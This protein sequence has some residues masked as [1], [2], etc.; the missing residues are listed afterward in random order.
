MNVKVYLV[1]RRKSAVCVS[2]AV[3]CLIGL[4]Y[5]SSFQ[6]KSPSIHQTNAAASVGVAEI[7]K[8]FSYANSKADAP[9]PKAVIVSA[10]NLTIPP[11][12]LSM[13]MLAA[14]QA[15]A[16]PG[17][18]IAPAWNPATPSTGAVRQG[19]LYLRQSLPTFSSTKSASSSATPQQLLAV[20]AA[21]Y[22]DTP[23][24]S[25]FA[26]VF[27]HGSEE[28]LSAPDPAKP[29]D[30]TPTNPFSEAK[31]K[32]EAEAPPPTPVAAAP[33]PAPPKETPPPADQSAKPTPS[34]PVTVPKPA[35]P[36]GPY[37][38]LGDFNG[39]GV[40]AAMS[41][42]RIDD[43]TFAFANGQR[44]FNLYINPA[45]VELQRSFAVDDFNGDGMADILVTSRAALF[46]A[47]RLGD[48]KGN[49][50]L[51]DTFVTGYEPT[52]PVPGLLQGTQRDILSVNMRTGTV[53]T[54]RKQDRYSQVLSQNL[55]NFLPDFVAR[56]T[57]MA[58][59][60]DRFIAAQAGKAVQV[61]QWQD[62]GTL[63]SSSDSIPPDPSIVLYKDF[64]QEGATGI[65]Q[66]YQVG[67]SAS[68]LLTIHSQ[69]FNVANFRVFPQIFL[70][71]G[72]LTKRGN[73]DVA[74]AYLLSSNTSK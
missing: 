13:E 21:Q 44:V 73:L 64:L 9:V 40:L 65:L 59:D 58:S 62:D 67:S 39:T 6:S 69:S 45:A 16:R 8:P 31:Q 14:E 17:G 18:D 74:V 27:K 24:Q 23:F 60:S 5:S 3:L 38:V 50:Q 66:V 51:A 47:L 30:Q 4:V 63:A 71:F 36:D 48:D 34:T 54:F 22:L 1:L 72:D 2:L 46:G 19:M 61:Y 43:G 49:F 25:L 41:A 53:V 68:V 52:V 7:A 32:A 35:A 20:G 33:P 28:S 55:I 11:D 57:E 70:V 15:Q 42:S 56:A 26:S 12:D 37:T 10:E 29:K